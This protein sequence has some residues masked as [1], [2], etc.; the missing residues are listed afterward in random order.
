NLIGGGRYEPHEGKPMLGFRGA[1]RYV[2]ATLRPCFEL[3]CRA[4]KRG[5]GTVGVTNGGGRGAFVRGAGGGG[6]GSR[7]VAP[8]APGAGGG[9]PGD[10]AAGHQRPETR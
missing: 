5:R 1:P 6:P 4:L 3:E 10:R 7:A 9:A 2:D 8:H